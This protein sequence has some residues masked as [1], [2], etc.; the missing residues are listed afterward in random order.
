M[1]DGHGRAKLDADVAI[2]GFGP[3][4]ALLAGLLGKRGISVVVVERDL[5]VFPLPR[6]AHIDHQGLRLI[7]ELGIL[8]ELLPRM[9]RN[10]GLDFLTADDELVIR[11]PG[12]QPSISGLPASMYFHQPPFDR[13]LRQA[14]TAMPS[15]DVHLGE[16][17]IAIEAYS[18]HVAV[19]V[20]NH[21]GGAE[22]R[23]GWLVGCDGAWSPVRESVGIRLENLGFDEKWV[24]VDLILKRPV[25]SLPDRA[26][27]I[28]DPKRPATAIP[29]PD[30]RFRFEVMVLDGEDALELQKP[31]NVLPMLSK[32]V[33][34]DA[35]EVERS[36]VYTFHGLLADPWR[37]GRC[38][39]AGD[40]AHQMPPFLGQGMNSGLRDVGNLAWKLA[41]VLNGEATESLL[42]TYGTER[43]PHVRHIIAAAIEYGRMTCMTDPEQAAERDRRWR[44]DMR[45]ATE[46]L[47]FSLPPLRRGPL[48]LEGGGELFPQPAHPGERGRL[49]DMVGQRFLVLG[50][51]TKSFG[52]SGR[53]WADRMGA[54]VVTLADLGDLRREL[55]KWMNVREVDIVVV[56]PD[57]YVMA[58]GNDA[59]RIARAISPY[60]GAAPTAV[61]ASS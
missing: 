55:E 13:R 48:V 29:I 37:V 61:P 17:L 7:Q 27:N 2:I 39:V 16:E 40:A 49:D 3:L 4:G 26:L 57:R 15:V 52:E 6:A 19:E 42:D 32:W 41:M 44:D 59:D 46:R 28:C 25:D 20:R 60:F 33:P 1:S 5:D 11:I 14:A 36:A 23:S 34:Q 10:P 56:R 38:L 47:P 45:P 12:N 22:I 30:G 51:D 31:E 8:D 35:V 50:R 58:S 24:V 54:Y 18:D 9:M 21:A 43:S 53:W